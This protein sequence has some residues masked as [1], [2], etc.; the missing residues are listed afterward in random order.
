MIFQY[1]AL[2]A[3]SLSLFAPPTVAIAQ[4]GSASLTTSSCTTINV[5]E[6][7]TNVDMQR[8]RDTWL[9][10]YNDYRASLDLAP[11]TSDATL[12]RTASN[13]S[14]YSVKRGTIDHKRAWQAPY[15]D[16]KGIESW[17]GKFG[18]TFKNVSGKTY[19][20]NIGWGVHSCAED[21]CTDQLIAAIRSTFDFFM[22]EKGMAYR[23]H[24]NAIVSDKFAKMGM[25]IGLN[26]ATKRY[27][28]TAHFATELT[29]EPVVCL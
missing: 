19:T 26:H 6:P 29:N 5:Q 21:D 7:P 10:W 12:D 14:Y 3:T 16:Y 1:G 15:Y 11:Y 28:L 2:L 27:Y 20:E 4:D 13:W 8:V 25:G 22:S 17:F 18:V 9:G 23:P 24:Y